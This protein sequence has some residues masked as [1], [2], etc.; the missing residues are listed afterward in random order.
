MSINNSKL[1]NKY[2]HSGE[3]MGVPRIR[4]LQLKGIRSGEFRASRGSLRQGIAGLRTGFS[5]Q[6]GQLG[7]KV[8]DLC[9]GIT[10][11]DVGKRVAEKLSSG[12]RSNPL[13]GTG[14]FSMQAARI[15]LAGNVSALAQV[16]AGLSMVAPPF[17]NETRPELR[18]NSGGNVIAGLLTFVGTN[19]L[20]NIAEANS[21]SEIAN[22]IDTSQ[23]SATSIIVGSLFAIGLVTAVCYGI[24]RLINRKLMNSQE[25]PEPTSITKGANIVID[26]LNFWDKCKASLSPEE[27]QLLLDRG[28]CYHQFPNQKKLLFIIQR[29][30]QNF[31]ELVRIAVYDPD[32]NSNTAIGILD[33]KRNLYRNIGII[34]RYFDER[35]PLNEFIAAEMPK[36]FYLDIDGILYPRLPTRRDLLNT[37]FW[38][39]DGYRMKDYSGFDWLSHTLM[40]TAGL[41]VYRE[42]GNENHLQL[43][44]VYREGTVRYYEK[45]F[46]ATQIQFDS[47]DG[48][49]LDI[50]LSK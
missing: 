9:L 3:H 45:S 14:L 37:A 35:F 31:V 1:K 15:R 5:S 20:S 10:H 11:L 6:S 40:H 7:P 48:T 25:N 19:M 39:S 46:G 8:L 33:L 13:Q 41:L 2:E 27:Y 32:S 49:S 12:M 30:N 24:Y 17:S 22:F 47:D 29:L 44:G 16:R 38:I 4:G 34:E 18:M 50:D 36:R 26:N 42:G 43:E 23:V 21:Y 28:Y